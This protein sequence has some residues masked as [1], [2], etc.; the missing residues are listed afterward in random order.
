MDSK[1]ITQRILVTGGAGFIGSHLARRLLGEGH[2]VQLLHR[3]NSNRDRIA[4]FISDVRLWEGDL[5]DVHS[6]NNVLQSAQPQVI[7]HLAG[8]SSL[9]HLDPALANVTESIERNI[10]SSINLLV[11]AQRC[12][13]GLQLI[14]RL[15]GFEE[16]GRSAVPYL[17]SQREEPVSPYSASQVAVT[18]Y[19]Q[20]L[21]P[22]LNYRA[23]TVRPALVYGPAQSSDFFIPALIEHCLRGQDFS[24]RSG[25]QGRDLLYVDDLVE[26][27]VRLLYVSLPSGEIVNVGSGREYLIADVA[28]KIVQLSGAKIRL[29]ENRQESADGVAHLYGSIDKAKR[30]LNWIPAI[31]LDEGLVRT[32][33]SFR[34]KLAS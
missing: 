6:L 34:K 31:E 4:D 7:Y 32:I 25:D 9:R 8:D 17:E 5:L 20:M 29:V 24:I 14:V 10:R 27:L 33:D 19:L 18:H 22:R 3:P 28:A 30:L 11:A 21:A 16:Y 2:E 13:S 12:S 1:T 26:A 23:V 15:G